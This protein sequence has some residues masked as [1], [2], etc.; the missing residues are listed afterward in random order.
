MSDDPLHKPL[1][2]RSW[3]ER[4]RW[5]P[6]AVPLL[7]GLFALA[8]AGAAVWAWLAPP[9]APSPVTVERELPPRPQQ[10]TA[11]AQPPGAATGRRKSLASPAKP[12][13]EG[14]M[15]IIDVSKLPDVPASDVKRRSAV[16]DGAALPN[17][18]FPDLVER[19]R[20]GPLPKRGRK[21]R[22]PWQAYARPVPA[23]IL[24]SRR[25]KLAVIVA[26]LG[27]NRA[28]TEEAIVFLPPEVT[29][30]FVPRASNLT[31]QTR[32]ARRQGHEFLL[33]VPMEPWGLS[34]KESQPD[35]LLTTLAPKENLRRLHRLLARTTG[36]IGIMSYAGQKFLQTGE[37][38]SPVLHELKKRGL[39]A[40]DDGAA[41]ESLLT[42]L[43]LVIRLPA[44]RAD[45][46][47]LLE[48]KEEAIRVRLEE[49]LRTA[50]ARGRALLVVSASRAGLSALEDW[51]ARLRVDD[52]APLLVP[53]SA[54]LRREN[55]KE[56]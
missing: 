43:G 30:A 13:R 8:L 41:S 16:D 2:P 23:S 31:A 42:S 12:R 34:K 6:G 45:V 50:R 36:Y 47:V 27:L 20:F 28:L 14:G 19:G 9:P 10:R 11:D 22:A 24:K 17:A 55:G 4:W 3:R 18:P 26:D 1:K 51:L 33:Q 54:L 7:A 37:A 46:R 44:L 49:A 40:V 52:S 21:G 56:K 53:A 38:L 32:K 35:M 48:T 29:L 15:R 39:M 25:P 5:R